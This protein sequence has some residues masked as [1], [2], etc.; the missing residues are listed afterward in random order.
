MVVVITEQQG[1]EGPKAGPLVSVL[2]GS[3]RRWECML[4]QMLWD[5]TYKLFVQVK[6]ERGPAVP[7]KTQPLV[8]P[9]IS[10]I[11]VETGTL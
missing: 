9:R 7:L 10:L 6:T 5:R 3:A 8:F 4:D 2:V 1:Q 11:W